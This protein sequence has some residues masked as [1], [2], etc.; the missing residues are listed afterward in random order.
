MS[1]N[2]PTCTD[3]CVAKVPLFSFNDCDPNTNRGQID[4]IYIMALGGADLA[5]WTQLA[6]WSARLYP[7][8]DPTV[9][10]D[11]I[12]YMN[13]IGEK[14]EASSDVK[15]IS[16][17]RKIV[18]DKTHVINFDVDETNEDNYDALRQIECGGNYKIWYQAGKYLYGG[19]DGIIAFIQ[20]NDMIPRE[21]K[22]LNVFKGVATWEA[23]FHPER[24]D[25]PML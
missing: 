15:E 13:V 11:A 5:D 24:I 21:R 20:E 3:G 2:N 1:I 18:L 9:T 14:P 19:N 22:E 25:N 12:Q 10:V 16:R 4:R 7:A 6:V 17:Q 8:L 23:Q